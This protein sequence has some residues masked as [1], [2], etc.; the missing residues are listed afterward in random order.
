MAMLM[1]EIKPP[2]PTG[3]NNHIHIW[4][5]PQEFPTQSFHAQ[6]QSTRHYTAKCTGALQSA[7]ILWLS[8]PLQDKFHQTAPNLPQTA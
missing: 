1:P 5:A 3:T 7:L 2:P 4:Q 8:V 6:Q